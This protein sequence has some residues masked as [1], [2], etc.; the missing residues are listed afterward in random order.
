M[1][2]TAR[3]LEI[4]CSKNSCE[5]GTKKGMF[6]NKSKMALKIKSQFFLPMSWIF[7]AEFSFTEYTDIDF[8]YCSILI[9]AAG[10]IVY[11]AGV[12]VKLG[13][14]KL[15]IMGLPCIFKD[16]TI[17]ILTEYT[18]DFVLSRPGKICSDMIVYHAG[19]AVKVTIYLVKFKQLQ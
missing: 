9:L 10:K 13:F 14:L 16:F 19:V 5:T 7:R 6:M 18:I 17:Y 4:M 2:K 15:K 1:L 8:V 12:A 11:H 3:N